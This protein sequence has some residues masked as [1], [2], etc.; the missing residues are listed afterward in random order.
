MIRQTP[1]YPILK[2][3]GR[4]RQGAASEFTGEI[5]DSS[6]LDQLRAAILNRGPGG[7]AALPDGWVV[8][9]N[10]SART[11]ELESRGMVFNRHSSLIGGRHRGSGLWIRHAKRVP[12]P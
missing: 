8:S 2:R 7:L 10:L 12:Q 4:I 5:R 9:T 1:H 3:A 11:V 6:S